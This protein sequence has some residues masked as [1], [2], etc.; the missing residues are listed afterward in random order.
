M[1]C[2]F[3]LDA[4]LHK[5]YFLGV[6]YCILI[7]IL[8]FY[9]GNFLSYLET[10]ELFQ[11]LLLRFFGVTEQCLVWAKA[12]N[13]KSRLFWIVCSS[14]PWIM[15]CCNLAGGIGYSLFLAS[16][17][18]CFSIFSDGSFLE[19]ISLYRCT[20]LL[21]SWERHLQISRYYCAFLFPEFCSMHVSHSC[22]PRI[23]GSSP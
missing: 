11:V 22:L 3:L 9:C 4:S 2:N 7:S 10:V 8:D 14:V 17:E 19:A 20:D 6:G 16:T 5:F 18:D 12:F 1:P 21:N 13:T 23:F 15:K